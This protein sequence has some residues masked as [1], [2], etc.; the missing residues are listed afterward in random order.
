LF[1]LDRIYTYFA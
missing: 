1:F